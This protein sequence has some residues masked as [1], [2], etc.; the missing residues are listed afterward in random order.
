MTVNEILDLARTMTHTT[1]AQFSNTTMIT[2]LNLEWKKLVRKIMTEVDENY[3]TETVEEDAVADQSAYGMATT[4]A[5]VKLVKIK[6][7]TTSD[8]YVVSREIDFSKQNHDFEYFASNQSTSNPVHQIIGTS[9]WIAPRFTTDT[10]GAAGNKQINYSYEKLQ[11]NLAVGGAE[12]TIGI[13]VDFHS[14]LAM[15]LKPYI[16]SALGKIN[17]KND[18]VAEARLELNDVLYLMK[19]RDDT[20]NSISIPSDSTLE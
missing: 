7:T 12:T 14:I 4:V 20:Y 11:T 1:A 17:E 3:F 18:A 13:S 2:W 16:Y 6:P 15:M 10:A 8:D 19:G 9:M 5:Y